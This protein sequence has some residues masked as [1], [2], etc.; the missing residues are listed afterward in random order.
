MWTGFPFVFAAIA[1]TLSIPLTLVSLGIIARGSAFAFRKVSTRQIQP[2]EA[3]ASQSSVNSSEGFF[4]FSILPVRRPVLHRA[5]GVPVDGRSARSPTL[6]VQGPLKPVHGIVDRM[7]SPLALLTAFGVT[8]RFALRTGCTA[9]RTERG[10]SMRVKKPT[11]TSFAQQPAAV[12]AACSGPD[13]TGETP[14]QP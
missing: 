14:R 5:C 9:R 4:Q 1:S 2:V 13:F 8:A 12:T 10:T 6:G 7:H 3:C 11:G